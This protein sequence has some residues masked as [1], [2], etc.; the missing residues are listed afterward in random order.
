MLGTPVL[1]LIVVLWLFVLAPIALRSRKPIRHTNEAFEE[2]RV[3]HEGGTEITAQRRRPR[4]SSEQVHYTEVEDTDYE[5]VDSEDILIDEPA[6]S[7]T[8][9]SKLGQAF[10]KFTKPEREHVV[11]GSV[12]A[13]LPQPAETESEEETD[14]A[15]GNAVALSVSDDYYDDGPDTYDY[16]DA[17]TNPAEFLHDD[18]DYGEPVVASAGPE[19]GESE[20]ADWIDEAEESEDAELSDE[21]LAFAARRRGRG[22][23]DPE[24]DAQAS[25][26][27]FQRRQRTLMVLGALLV[28]TLIIGAVQGGM[29]WIAPG[30]VAALSVFYLYAL[31]QQVRAENELR[32]RRIRH[33][34]RARL[35]VRSAEDEELGMPARLRRPGA[36]VLELDDAS[37]DFEYLPET[38]ANFDEVEFDEQ[39]PEYP[40]PRRVS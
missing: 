25:T 9:F 29:A 18:A 26:N 14:P 22:G 39:V 31:R 40:V 15:V 10:S 37:P 7:A 2:T 36:V 33:M 1:G 20:D 16:D 19:D 30:V 27:R 23:Y 21:D 6:S 32:A 8:P 12:V 28:V 17:Y 13:E 5:L 4:L 24:A 35:G 3:I 11:D 34:R 38:T